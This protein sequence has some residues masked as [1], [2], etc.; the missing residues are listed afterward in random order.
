MPDIYDWIQLPG[1]SIEHVRFS[2][3]ERVLSFQ[4]SNRRCE[5]SSEYVA[6]E[7][8]DPTLPLAL[9]SAQPESGITQPLDPMVLLGRTIEEVSV[10]Y[11]LPGLGLEAYLEIRFEDGFLIR[12]LSEDPTIPV[13]IS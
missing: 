12:V 1:R 6:F 4:L 5:S 11:V 3:D 10:P 8:S 9:F 7:S 2:P 13:R